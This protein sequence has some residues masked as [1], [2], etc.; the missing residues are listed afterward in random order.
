[1]TTRLGNR[2]ALSHITSVAMA[3]T[4]LAGRAAPNLLRRLVPIVA[5]AVASV[6]LGIVL[7][8]SAVI[9][10]PMGSFGIVAVAGLVLLW[11]MPDLPLVSRGLIRRAF[12]VM[13]IVDLVVPFYY[14]VQFSGLPWISARRVVTFALIAPFVVAVAASS[15][16]RRMIAER[17]RASPLIIV[18]AAGFLVMG[19]LSLITSLSA[20]ES[21]SGLVDAI[22]SWYVPFF[23]MIYIIKNNDDVVFILKI[24]CVCALVVTAAGVLEFRL[25]Q[26][27]FLKIFPPSMLGNLMANNPRLQ[28]LL[29]GP[30]H[31]RNGHYRAE[32]IFMTAISFSEFEVIVIPIGLFFAFHSKSLFDKVL[33]WTV[34]IAAL[35]GIF[36]S[37]SRGG[38]TGAIVSVPVF[39]GMWSIRTAIQRRASLA[40][41][42]VGAA[43]LILVGCV[44]GLIVFSHTIHD[45]ILG[46]AAQASSTDARYFQWQI[47]LPYIKSNPITGYG[48]DVGGALVGQGNLAYQSIDSYYLSLVLEV[49]VPGLFLFSGM[50][51]LPILYGVRAY[52]SDMSEYGAM[53][54]ALACSFIGFAQSRLVVSQRE[55]HTVIFALLA[56]VI[57]ANYEHARRRAPQGQGARAMRDRHYRA[58]TALPEGG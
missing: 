5:W 36:A 15:D 27:F 54:G 26:N 57:V 53:A 35:V 2:F 16:V 47:A 12:F 34:A 39:I 29:P 45:M 20:A 14:T 4:R 23:A 58:Q 49:G 1:M 13:L 51:L 28:D 40:P 7:G 52:L 24:I 8:F 55:N 21:M 10:P 25:E 42:I 48:F 44:L 17:L 22:L 46:G 56:I 11:V 18:C 32:S 19:L 6:V 43:G 50:L 30:E 31:F 3:E 9:L 38:Y 41:A 33:G 37:G